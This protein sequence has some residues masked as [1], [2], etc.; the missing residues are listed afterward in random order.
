MCFVRTSKRAGDNFEA[1]QTISLFSEALKAGCDDYVIIKWTNKFID[2]N[3]TFHFSVAVK[4][5]VILVPCT[6]S[7]E[8]YSLLVP[9]VFSLNSMFPFARGSVCSHIATVRQMFIVYG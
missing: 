2:S 6:T 1:S 9:Y 8:K 4:V 3:L 7:I 5:I